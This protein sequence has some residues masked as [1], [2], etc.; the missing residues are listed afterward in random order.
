MSFSAYSSDLPAFLR[1]LKANNTKAWFEADRDRF[2]ELVQFV[3]ARPT[4]ASG[5]GVCLRLATLR[6][7]ERRTGHAVPQHR[8]AMPRTFP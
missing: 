3:N 1:E 7:I 5:A 4:G 2:D 6:G 8:G